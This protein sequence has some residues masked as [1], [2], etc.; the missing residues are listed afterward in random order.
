MCFCFSYLLS[1]YEVDKS[2]SMLEHFFT[3]DRK[4]RV[5]RWV[6]SCVGISRVCAATR[7]PQFRGLKGLR[8]PGTG[9]TLSLAKLLAQQDAWVQEET[10]KEILQTCFKALWQQPGSTKDVPVSPGDLPSCVH[11]LLS[12]LLVTAADR[13]VAFKNFGWVWTALRKSMNERII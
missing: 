7:S 13:G 3:L 5:V 12:A 1:Y 11:G 9:L 4:W 8:Q 10:A 2:H 6:P